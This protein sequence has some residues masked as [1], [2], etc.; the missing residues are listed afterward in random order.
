MTSPYVDW[1][2]AAPLSARQRGEGRNPARA[3]ARRAAARGI[4]LRAGIAAWAALVLYCL[5]SLVA[6]PAG[7]A[8]YRRLE[9][10]NEAM[11]DNI[12]ALGT[13]NA[14]LRQELESLR[15]DADRAAREARS[16]GYLRPGESAVIVV[17]RRPSPA[18]LDPGRVLGYED[19]PS[20]PDSAL[21]EI[22]LGAF[23]AILAASLA[24]RKQDRG[25]RAGSS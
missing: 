9:A 11:R 12:D 22:S 3:E 5:L 16:L 21:K 24:P 14:R 25:R 4:A 13:A 2:G 20:W 1:L 7:F 15:S 8:A 10:R 6:G 18:E 19:P 17:G 23:L